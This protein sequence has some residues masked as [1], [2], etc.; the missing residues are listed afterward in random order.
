MVRFKVIRASRLLLAAA[1]GLFLLVGAALVLRYVLNS[2]GTAPAA[3]ASL[4]RADEAQEAKTAVVFASS[5]GVTALAGAEAPRVLIYHTHTHEAYEQVSDDPYDAVEAWRTTDADHSVVRVGSELARRLRGFGFRVVHDTTDHEGQELSTAYDR[6]LQTLQGYRERF[7]LY[8]D[9]H[10]DAVE[11]GESVDQA[12]LMLLVG[13]GVGF[14]EKPFYTQNLA[15]AKALSE[16][17]NAIRPGACK[18]VLVKDGRYNQHVGVFSVLV[19]VGHN[20]NTLAQALDAVPPLAEGI[21]RLLI[22][23][24]RPE[25]TAMRRAWAGLSDQ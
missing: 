11:P 20:R 9:L 10:R 12:R 17:I 15:F 24:P 1:I 8:I 16:E 2:P 7:D 21:R 14:D 19:E 5:S 23:A 3:N 4:V 22:D 6:S 13:N 18:G 25:L